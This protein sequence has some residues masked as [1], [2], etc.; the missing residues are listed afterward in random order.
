[1]TWAYSGIAGDVR[2]T[3]HMPL[4][5]NNINCSPDTACNVQGINAA[6]AVHPGDLRGAEEGRPEVGGLQ[7]D[8]QQLWASPASGEPRPGGVCLRD[9]ANEQGSISVLIAFSGSA[10][11]SLYNLLLVIRAVSGLADLGQSQC[12]MRD[13]THAH[14]K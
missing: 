13:H 11:E 10:W 8:G 12:S 3:V 4:G 5:S 14:L 6:G 2:C 9:L 7:G 1:M